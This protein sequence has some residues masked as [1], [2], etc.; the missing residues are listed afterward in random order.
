MAVAGLV[1]HRLVQGGVEIGGEVRARGLRADGGDWM[2]GIENP[3][4]AA[5]TSADTLHEVVRLRNA[6]IATSGDYRNYFVHDGQRYSHTL[7]PRTGWPV[8]HDLAAVSVVAERAADADALATALMV[9]GPEQGL[10]LAVRE[11]IA[12]R[13]MLRTGDGLEVVHSPAYA[14]YVADH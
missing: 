1:D 12:A 14:A 13:W 6:A 4:A 5:A 7:D 9:L 8:S 10:Q 2:I 3:V 11:S